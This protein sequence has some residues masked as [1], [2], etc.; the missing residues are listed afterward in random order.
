[1]HYI[2]SQTTRR[3]LLGGALVLMA[4]AAAPAQAQTP[5]APQTLSGVWRGQEQSPIGP[6]AVEVIFFPNGTYS[7]AHVAGSLMTRDVG[8]YEIVQNWI[9][10]RLTNYEP[11]YYMNR[12]MTRPMS[13]TWVV[14]RFDGRILQ[15]TV[16]GNSVVTV[17]RV[18]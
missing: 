17:Q 2:V 7:R 14:N 8:T 6:M 11:K 9:H 3:A 13:D 4:F 5:L 10:F 1:M 12:P 16:G 15:A 18:Q